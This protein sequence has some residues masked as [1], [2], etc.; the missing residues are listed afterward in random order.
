MDARITLAI[1]NNAKTTLKINITIFL[2]DV[3]LEDVFLEDIGLSTRATR[4]VW[5][6]SRRRARGLRVLSLSSVMSRVPR[7]R[8]VHYFFEVISASSAFCHNALN[9]LMDGRSIETP[10]EEMH[11]LGLEC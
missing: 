3:F 9:V 6:Y 10:L 1:G 2:E 11:R 4:R 7:K 8:K 5:L